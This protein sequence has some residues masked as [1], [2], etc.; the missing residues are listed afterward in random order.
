VTRQPFSLIVGAA[1]R[2]KPLNHQHTLLIGTAFESGE[3]GSARY[4]CGELKSPANFC[5]L[6]GDGAT[7]RLYVILGSHACR[8]GM[9][10]LEHKGIDYK[11]VTLPTLLHPVGARLAGFRGEAPPRELG[12]GSRRTA[13]VA[14]GDRMGTVPALRMNAERVQSNRNISRFLDRVQPEPAL[15]PADPQARMAVEE[16]ERWGDDVFQ[17]TARRLAIAAALHGLDALYERGSAGRL[18]PILWHRDLARRIGIRF[19][20]SAFSTTRKSEAALL[21]ELP[22]QLDK[23][24]A[25]IEAGV[26][27]G[28]HLNAADMMIAPSIALLGYR[29]DVRSSLAERPA[30]ELADRLLP[31]PALAA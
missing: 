17:M 27:N 13:G 2:C 21:A 29:L 26:L 19:V 9:L 31:E 7:P 4:A 25:L 30:M 16:A 10:L 6:T 14:F 1:L 3:P 23:V 18:G 20:M 5:H 11:T 8:T 15:F 22:G 24:D 28:E 12:A